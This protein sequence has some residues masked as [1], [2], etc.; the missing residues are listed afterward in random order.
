MSISNPS[1]DKPTATLPEQPACQQGWQVPAYEQLRLGEG[2]ARYAVCVFVLNESER[3]LAQLA[4]MQSVGHGLDIVLA[5]GGSSDGS[6]EPERLKSLGVHALLVKRGPGKLSAQMRM[7]LAWCLEQGYQGIVTMDGNNKDDPEALTRFAQAL[8][9]GFDHV[10]G[11]RFVPGGQAIN[12]PAS[13]YWGIKLVHAPLVSLA[14]R[15]RYTDTTNGFRAYSRRLLVDPR[16]APFRDVFSCY[17][18]HYYLA[19]RAARLGLRVTEIPVTRAYPA[20]GA[21]PT[22]IHGWR[23][24]VKVLRT[25]LDACA[26][27]FDPVVATNDDFHYQPR[28]KAA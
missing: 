7:A 1:F 20:D 26:G 24:N 22:K 28:S 12:T 21:V 9:Q 11:S 18:L 25:L 8:D 16:V 4:R 5:D 14:A 23:G 15:F 10:Q 3:I 6:T 17:E 19:I 27:R 2:R 13:R